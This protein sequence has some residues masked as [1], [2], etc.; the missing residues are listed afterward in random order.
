MQWL[1]DPNQSD[2]DKMKNLGREALRKKRKYTKGE[3]VLITNLMHNFFI[4]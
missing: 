1:E 4:L 3:L 2:A